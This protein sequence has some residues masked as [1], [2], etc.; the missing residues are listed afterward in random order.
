MSPQEFWAIVD[1]RK[2]EQKVGSLPL[3][4]FEALRAMLPPTEG[5]T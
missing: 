3:S 5:R 2:P 1:A 4:E